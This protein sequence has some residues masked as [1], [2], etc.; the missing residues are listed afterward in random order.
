MQR[1]NFVLG[2][3]ALSL[4]SLLKAQYGAKNA[5]AKNIIYVFLEG[6]FRLKKLLIQNPWLL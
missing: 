1:R 3:S 2:L 5:K 6:E 4:P